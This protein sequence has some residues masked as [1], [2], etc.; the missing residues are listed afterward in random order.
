[1]QN[2]PKLKL[3]YFPLPD[4][5]EAIRLALFIANVDFEDMT[6]SPEEVGKMKAVLPFNQVPVLEVDGN[7]IAQ[8]FAILRYAGILAGLYA[9]TD[10]R[11]ASRVD[12]M[13][14]LTDKMYNCP[15]WRMLVAEQD[16]ATLLRLRV[17]LAQDAIP[18]TLEVLENLVARFKRPYATGAHLTVADLAIYALVL[19][20]KAGRPGFPVTIADPCQNLQ[21]VFDQVKAHPKVVEWNAAHL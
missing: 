1:M 3:V 18:K 13:F 8:S 9:T 11:V 4:R 14:A 21:R 16:P 2:T 17:R 5:A 20:L 6:V 19:V 7:A 10:I 12:E 15:D